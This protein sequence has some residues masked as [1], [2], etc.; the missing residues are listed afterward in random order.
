MRRHRLGELLDSS[1]GGHGPALQRLAGE[2]PFLP[3]AQLT[4]QDRPC[5]IWPV[6]ATRSGKFR[7]IG[8]HG[9]TAADRTTR[10]AGVNSHVYLRQGDLDGAVAAWGEFLDCAEGVQSVKIT[11]ALTDL[12]IRL[13]PYSKAP[14]VA[15]LDGRAAALL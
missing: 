15:E 4:V 3:H 12:R 6:A 13:S 5:G 14:G 2:P 8:C 1:A 7:W 9:G 11:D 10:R